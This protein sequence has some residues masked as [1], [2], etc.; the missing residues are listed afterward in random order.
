M[1]ISSKITVGVALAGLAAAGGAAFTG[2]G[3]ANNAPATQFIGGTVSQSVTGATLSGI[4]Y[5]FADD[6]A[7]TQVNSIT[8]A[9]TG[10]ENGRTVTVTPAGGTG[11]T[12]ACSSTNNNASACSYSPADS[13]DGYAGLNSLAVAV[14]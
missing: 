7:K 1:R 13:E 10:T 3:L 8:L 11:G 12:F 4:T 14:S 2:T 5:G 9:F 6:Q